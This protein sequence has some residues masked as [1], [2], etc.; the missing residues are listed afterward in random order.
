MVIRDLLITKDWAVELPLGLMA[1]DYTETVSVRT[2]LSTFGPNHVEQSGI[3]VGL[4][5]ESQ[6]SHCCGQSCIGLCHRRIHPCQ[7]LVQGTCGR[8]SR[9]SRKA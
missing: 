5:I 6:C 2:A 8:H 4:Q 7:Y 3:A 1:R 9:I